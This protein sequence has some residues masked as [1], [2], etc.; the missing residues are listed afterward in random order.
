LE[1]ACIHF[2]RD[3]ATLLDVTS[4]RGNGHLIRKAHSR[5]ML[6]LGLALPLPVSE[7]VYRIVFGGRPTSQTAALTNVTTEEWIVFSAA[8]MALTTF[9]QFGSVR[10]PS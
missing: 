1:Q 2:L 6:E 7:V 8:T 9:A 4:L 10:P 3:L 5:Y